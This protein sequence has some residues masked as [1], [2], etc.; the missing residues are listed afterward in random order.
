MQKR[1]EVELTLDERAQLN[2]IVHRANPVMNR[3][4]KILDLCLPFLS[5]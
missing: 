1:H 5:S 2:A 4:L 3:A